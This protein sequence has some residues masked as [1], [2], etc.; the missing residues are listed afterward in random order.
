MMQS[1]WGP[2]ILA[3]T[4]LGGTPTL[5]AAADEQ[6]ADENADLY[7]YLGTI[8]GRDM[9]QMNLTKAE[10]DMVLQGISDAASG[11][12]AEFDDKA[13]GPRLQALLTSKQETLAADEKALSQQYV[14]QMAEEPGAVTTDSGLVIRELEAGVGGSP[15]A[16]STVKAHYHGTLRDGTVFDSSVQRGEP[17]E[18]SLQRVIPCWT[19]G[20]A[21]MK[22]G[23]KSKLT[24]PSS[25][26]Y[27]DRG[28]GPIPGGAALTFE[29]QLLQIVN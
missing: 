2:A 16:E 26:A 27:G 21:L 25:I 1:K 22:E 19:E 17:L 23:G 7:Y 5:S 13:Y 18:I 14:S 15:T 24:C 3:A 9:S 8:Y 12:A 29:V 28:S 10:I 4:L 6:A 11:E 20:I